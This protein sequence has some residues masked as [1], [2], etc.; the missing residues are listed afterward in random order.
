MFQP[1]MLEIRVTSITEELYSCFYQLKTCVIIYSV[2]D[3]RFQLFY[4]HHYLILMFRFLFI[5]CKI[6]IYSIY[7]FSTSI[8]I[9]LFSFFFSLS[10]CRYL[11]HFL[12]ILCMSWTTDLR[13]SICV[14]LPMKKE[15]EGS[16]QFERVMFFF[17]I[18]FNISKDGK[19]I[20][21]LDLL[22]CV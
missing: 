18:F 20:S 17:I 21:H 8:W 1:E 13:G 6:L 11:L 16:V 22:Q 2:L 10:Q 4:S 14:C 3:V 9:A 15:W 19:P 5:L 12:W 7:V